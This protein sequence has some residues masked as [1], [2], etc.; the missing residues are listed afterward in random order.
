MLLAYNYYNGKIIKI[1]Y[2]VFDNL[3][4]PVE[5]VKVLVFGVFFGML[6]VIDTMLRLFLIPLII[7]K[8]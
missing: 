2:L 7:I 4:T 1:S 5:L 3:E 8:R 6:F